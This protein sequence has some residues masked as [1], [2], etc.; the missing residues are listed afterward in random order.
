MSLSRSS[1]DSI[2]LSFAS[3]SVGSP[4]DPLENKLKAISSAGFTAI[5]LG[6]PDLLSFSKNFQKKEIR[7]DDYG[8]LCKAGTEVKALCKKHNLGIMM[9]Q[10][11]SK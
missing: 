4:D 7:E 9:L 5:E 2:P 8:N 11:S 3:V 6:F 10:R 1:L